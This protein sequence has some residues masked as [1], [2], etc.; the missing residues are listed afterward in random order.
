MGKNVHIEFGRTEAEV[1]VWS[2]F[3]SR[4]MV[5]CLKTGRTVEI[6]DPKLSGKEGRAW[7]YRPRPEV[8]VEGGARGGLLAMLCRSSGQDVLVLLAPRTYTVVKAVA[9][10]LGLGSEW[11]QTLHIHGRWTPLPDD[12]A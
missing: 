7:G 11:L 6:R 12:S 4:V 9:G 2:D 1:L 5:W 10:G 3:A 8:N